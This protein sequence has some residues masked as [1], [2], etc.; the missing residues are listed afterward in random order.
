MLLEYYEAHPE[1]IR[2][3]T[4]RNE[5]IAFVKAGLKDLSIT[6][7]SFSWGIPVPDDEKHVIYVWVDALANY[8]TALGWGS[9]DTSKF[10][11][12]WPADLHIVGKEI[13]RFHCVYWP[14]FLHG[15]RP[16]AAEIASSAWLAALRR[17]QDVEVARQHRARRNDSRRPRRRRAALL[18]AAR[19]GLRPRRQLLFDALVQRYNSD[20]ANGYGNLVSRTLS[21][22]GRYFDG[23]VPYA[24]GIGIQSLTAQLLR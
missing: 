3:E 24:A 6:R 10:D 20:L 21:M 4:R 8:I 15:R 5:V 2:P 1:F 18:P 7:T 16:A 13:T 11:K 14:A 23:L 19:N 9:D 17:E 22:I 12:F